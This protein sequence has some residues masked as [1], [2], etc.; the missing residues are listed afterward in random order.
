MDEALLVPDQRDKFIL[1]H[2]QHKHQVIHFTT[3]LND[4]CDGL[5]DVWSHGQNPHRMGQ[6]DK[7]IIG[8]GTRVPNAIV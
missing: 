4:A 7:G 5:T 1:G 6:E 3:T 2:Q 8:W